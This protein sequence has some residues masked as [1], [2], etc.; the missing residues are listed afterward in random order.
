[1]LQDW[2]KGRHAEGEE[3][4]GLVVEEK[5]R[6]GGRAP[7]NERLME[8]ARRIE[9]GELEPSLDNAQLLLGALER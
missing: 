5:R 7:V 8:V 6:R 4:N 9:S 1:V 3:I 2:M